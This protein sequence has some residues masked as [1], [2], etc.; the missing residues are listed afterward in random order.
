LAISVVVQNLKD[1]IVTT[2]TKTRPPA[3]LDRHFPKFR[4]QAKPKPPNW[5][6]RPVDP[7]SQPSKLAVREK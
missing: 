3:A 6:R 2:M 1:Q 4:Y 7:D 5:P